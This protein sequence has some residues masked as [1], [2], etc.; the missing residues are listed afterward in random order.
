MVKDASNPE[1]EGKVFLYKYGKKIFDKINER[2]PQELPDG[3]YET[4]DANDPDF[5]KFNPFNFWEGANFKLKARK[6]E[7]YP[8]YDKSE[9]EGP[10]KL[11]DDAKIEK[12]WRGA[13]SLKEFVSPDQYKSYEE[14]KEK[15]D[16]VCSTGSDFKPRTSSAVE[17]E[18]EDEGIASVAEEDDTMS[19]FNRLAS[20]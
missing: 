2:L 16:K 1:N 14:L 4:H 6:F 15:F 8:N 13:Y 3:T 19:Y 17:V 5:L 7:G 20:E 11:G 9:F 12:I 10:S 18:T